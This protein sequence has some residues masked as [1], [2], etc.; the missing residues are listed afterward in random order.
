MN[1]LP[2]VYCRRLNPALRI[3]SR[4]T[5]ERNVKRSTAPAW[6]FVSEFTTLG[7]ESVMSA[8]VVGTSGRA[9]RRG[10]ELFSIDFPAAL[11]GSRLAESR[12][13]SAPA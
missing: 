13:G 5:H 10:V 3:V 8:A 2:A 1:N 7:V 9:R 4:I 11:G 6:D 12:I